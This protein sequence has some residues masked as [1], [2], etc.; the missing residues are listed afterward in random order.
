MSKELKQYSKRGARINPYMSGL[1][2]IYRR[3][4]W[5]INP[6]SFVS[7]HKLKSMMG[8]YN[9]QKAVILCN[10]P[11]LLEVDFDLLSKSGVYTFGLNKINLLFDKRNFKPSSIVSVAP[12]VVEQNSS[13]FE[14][15]DIDL[16]LS[17]QALK[18]LSPREN[19]IFLKSSSQREFA[20]DCSFSIYEGYTVTFVALQ[21]A[22]HMGFKAV[23]LVGCDHNYKIKGN[24]NEA[25]TAGDNDVNHFDPNYFAAGARL[26]VPDLL[27]NEIS[28]MMARRVY[29]E[30]GRRIFN[31]T[32]DGN[33]N[34]FERISLYSFL[35]EI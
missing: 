6:Q 2:E 3:L 21:L 22:Y 30:Y 32:V 34:V 35:N 9:G 13:F 17:S 24:I 19:I 27:E 4:K 5:D 12:F 1:S 14:K 11:S 20:R 8:Q 18:Y 29:T 15:T 7:R 28:Y 26:D 31:A 16:F 33:L 10:G 25:V 23:A